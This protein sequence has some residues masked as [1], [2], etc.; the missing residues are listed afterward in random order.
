M[1]SRK[2]IFWHNSYV[3]LAIVCMVLLLCPLTSHPQSQTE[4]LPMLT[5]IKDI[6]GPDSLIEHSAGEYRAV[7]TTMS[8]DGEILGGNLYGRVCG[9]QWSTVPPEAG[10][11]EYS[12][13]SGIVRFYPSEVP[14]NKEIQI[15]ARVYSFTEPKSYST[16]LTVTI[17][18]RPDPSGWVVSWGGGSGLVCHD[19]AVDAEGNVYVTGHFEGEVDFDPTPAEE[20]H[21]SGNHTGNYLVRYNPD[22]IFQW[23]RTWDGPGNE[24]LGYRT[25]WGINTT[26]LAV[27]SD[28]NVLVSGVFRDSDSPEAPEC[29][30]VLSPNDVFLRKFDPS[31]YELWVK[32]WNGN[33]MHT[34]LANFYWLFWIIDIAS[35]SSGNT[36]LAATIYDTDGPETV[37]LDPGPQVMEY[38]SES[39][40]CA[41]ALLK[42]NRD[43]EFVWTKV[44]RITPEHAFGC[45]LTI[46]SAE[47]VYVLGDFAGTVDFDPDNPGRCRLTS[48]SDAKYLVRLDPAGNAEWAGL[49]SSD[50]RGFACNPLGGIITE[51]LNS[52]FEDE[53]IY[54]FFIKAISDE[55]FSRWS[56]RGDPPENSGLLDLSVDSHGNT[57]AVV[58]SGDGLVEP[59]GS[60]VH[61]CEKSGI[62]SLVKY[63]WY[64]D[65]LWQ[66]D[67]RLMRTAIGLS[68][69]GNFGIAC[70]ADGDV[71]MSS[72]CYGFIDNR[73]GNK[74]RFTS[75]FQ[76]TNSYPIDL[77]PGDGVYYS[78][79]YSVDQRINGTGLFLMKIGNDGSW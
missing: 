18:N 67:W 4:P 46:D 54:R 69:V 59:L 45:F 44:V 11:F 75:F 2:R 9:Y 20:I 53:S 56:V 40:P 64:G 73:W 37:D 19:I 28:G 17:E 68:S 14:E 41:L 5:G 26:S 38:P 8:H 70:N 57:Y 76:D 22:G 33:V 27:D 12:Y 48:S 49:F 72:N 25:P 10:V 31:G 3:G 29:G 63:D 13:N 32:I 77:D 66:M 7:V 52:Y 24:G 55:G 62:T 47:D 79:P 50:T 6:S 30:H 1:K 61:N 34:T 16:S 36:Y 65:L 23:A 43:G 42:L 21:D 15:V 51:G 35:D 60:E 78:V 39:V 58:Y 71:F 74:S